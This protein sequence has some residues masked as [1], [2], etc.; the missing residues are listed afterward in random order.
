ML[1]LLC[2]AL[3]HHFLI[4]LLDLSQLLL[5]LLLLM[6]KFVLWLGNLL[7]GLLLICAVLSVLLDRV[8]QSLKGLVVI[9]QKGLKFFFLH[10]SV[11]RCIRRCCNLVLRC[12]NVTQLQ[13]LLIQRRSGLLISTRM[14][15]EIQRELGRLLILVRTSDHRVIINCCCWGKRH[16]S[17]ASLTL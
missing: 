12:A 17:A 10:S 11:I 2:S 5:W 4:C 14:H 8:L 16:F 9:I 6:S 15:Q 7:L 13:G 3:S 1:L